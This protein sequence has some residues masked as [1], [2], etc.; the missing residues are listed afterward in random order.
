MS[1]LQ[2]LVSVVILG[3]KIASFKIPHTLKRP[4]PSK[5]AMLYQ[6]PTSRRAQL[7][8]ELHG[9]RVVREWWSLPWF[10]STDQVR[11]LFFKGLGLWGFRV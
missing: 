10:R 11:G 3:I 1:A 9:V 5:G 8:E 2:L 6:Y 7:P 4:T